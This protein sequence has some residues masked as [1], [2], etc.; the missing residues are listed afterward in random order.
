M[1]LKLP[2]GCEALMGSF[3]SK[4]RSQVRKPEKDGLSVTLG[5]AEFVDDF[6][7]VPRPSLA[8]PLSALRKAGFF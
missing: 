6:C 2:G 1:L 4:L 8:E 5:G 7:R 3:P